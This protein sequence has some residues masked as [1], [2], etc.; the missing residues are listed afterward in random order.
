M[1]ATSV[2]ST[3]A[4]MLA[5]AGENVLA[6]GFTDAN[7][8]AWGVQAEAFLCMLANF[9]LVTNVGALGVK[10]K[11]ILSEY[12]ARYVAMCGIAYDMNEFTSRVEAEDMINLHTFRMKQIEKRLT[13][14]A[15][16]SM[17]VT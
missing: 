5:M 16:A 1:V 9:D 3:D 15:L 12:I 11:G 14:E 13:P 6:A 2:L 4:E 7:K 10:F 8:T 17:G